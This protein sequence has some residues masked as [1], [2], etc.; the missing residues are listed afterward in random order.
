[1]DDPVRRRLRT[2]RP[3]G[4]TSPDPVTAS[5]RPQRPTQTRP[6]PRNPGHAAEQASR[7]KPAPKSLP[8][9]NQPTADSVQPPSIF[10]RWIEAKGAL[11]AGIASVIAAFGLTWKGIGEFFGRAAAKGEAQLWDAE[12]DWAIAHRFTTLRN[13]PGKKQIKQSRALQD[14]EPMQE[15]LRCHKQWKD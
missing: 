2:A 10:G 1:M 11:G 4:L 14:D 7:R 13:Y 9:S 3:G 8:R 6:R 12:I 5:Q 15:H